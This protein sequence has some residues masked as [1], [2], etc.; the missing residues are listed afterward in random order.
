MAIEMVGISRRKFGW[1]AI[2][3]YRCVGFGALDGVWGM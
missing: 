3:T 2:V 1:D